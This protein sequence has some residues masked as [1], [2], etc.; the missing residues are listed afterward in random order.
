M[1]ESRRYDNLQTSDGK[2]GN[3]CIRHTHVYYTERVHRCRICGSVGGGSGGARDLTW[4]R[5]IGRWTTVRAVT[6]VGKRP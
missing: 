4:L 2:C 1:S 6:G 5:F 3:K